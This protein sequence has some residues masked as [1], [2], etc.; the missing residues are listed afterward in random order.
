M[1]NLIKLGSAKFQ[2]KLEELKSAYVTFVTGNPALIEQVEKSLKASSY[3]FEALSKNYETSIFIA[4]IVSF[5]C[6]LFAY[7]NSHLLNTKKFFSNSEANNLAEKIK[8][9]LT[10]VEFSQAF[11]EITASRVGG[12][13]ARWAV[14]TIICLIKVLLRCILLFLFDSGIQTSSLCSLTNTSTLMAKLSSTDQ[15]AEESEIIYVGRRSG[16]KM[17]TLASST[18]R[19]GDVPGS[20]SSTSVL[21]ALHTTRLTG[22]E[23]IGECLH[24]IRPLVHVMAVGVFGTKSFIPWLSALVTDSSS[25]VL[26]QRTI[27][28]TSSKKRLSYNP[29]E[30]RELQRRYANLMLYLLR[31]PV[32][33][34]FTG[35]KL[36]KTLNFLSDNVPLARYILEPFSKYLPEW[37][38]VYFYDWI[39]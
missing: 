5:S 25:H 16:H 1:S 37:Q 27:Q 39:D 29:E 18:S 3:L 22:S 38:K 8:Q 20:G 24:A 32:Y 28:S 15:A 7:A 33:D 26:L 34:K 12:P 11:V 10:V 30:T 19:L 6:N 31:S 36:L 9:T 23:K 2:R 17:R 35:P 4:E 14:I 13:G 21:S